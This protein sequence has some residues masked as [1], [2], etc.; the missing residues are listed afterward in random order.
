MTF[1]IGTIVEDC[2]YHPMLVLEV[3]G[4]DIAGISLLDYSRPRC[5]SIK[6]C[7]IIKLLPH[8]VG[9]IL[10]NRQ[11]YFDAENNWRTND[12][13]NIH[14]YDKV[15]DFRESLGLGRSK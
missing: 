2:S 6:H 12:G 14:A 1:K 11:L 7:G 4:D 5:C 8:E 10:D 13:F 15:F 3:D 9:A